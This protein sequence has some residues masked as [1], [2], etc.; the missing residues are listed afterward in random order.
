MKK[1]KEKRNKWNAQNTINA[2]FFLINSLKKEKSVWLLMK[3]RNF[4]P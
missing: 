2:L 1:K 3:F 4:H